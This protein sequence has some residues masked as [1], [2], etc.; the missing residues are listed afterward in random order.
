MPGT[1]H[2]QSQTET[3][4]DSRIEDERESDV[5]RNEVSTP[6]AEEFQTESGSKSD[7][8]SSKINEPAYSLEIENPSTSTS[9]YSESDD[10]PEFDLGKWL[11]KSSAMTR[12][13]KLH[14]L[15]NVWVPSQ[16]YDFRKDVA[17]TE[18]RFIHDWLTTYT[19]WLCYS[20]KLKGALCLFCV[21]FPPT[22]VHG[23]LGAFIVT[24]F[25][26]Y[27]DVH[28]D[29]KNHAKSQWHKQSTKSAK[30]FVDDLPVNVIAIS[31]HQSLINQ[32]RKILSSI[33]SIIIFC[34]TH[35]LPL[36]GKESGSGKRI[37]EFSF[38]TNDSVLT[39]FMSVIKSYVF[40][41]R[42]FL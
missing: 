37:F 24:P 26:R 39:K 34:G 4:K 25:K 1:S 31:R 27:K 21:L 3:S 18:R 11:G 2:E 8:E 13:Q 35:D 12:P 36:R 9:S 38:F 7:H 40:I 32:N 19:P 6:S 10:S 22:T 17:D 16:S 41:H 30:C 23:V 42:G 5:G 28:E 20:K 15:K 33:I 14:L 29:C